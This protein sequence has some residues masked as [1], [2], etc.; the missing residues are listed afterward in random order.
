MESDFN[1]WKIK[2]LGIILIIYLCI[3]IL[4]VSSLILYG[5]LSNNSTASSSNTLSDSSKVY[6]HTTINNILEVQNDIQ[7]YFNQNQ[8]LPLTLNELYPTGIPSYAEDSYTGYPYNYVVN[9]SNTYELCANFEA[10][11]STNTQLDY[12][13]IYHNYGSYCLDFTA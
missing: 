10:S 7:T 13:N 1:L 3:L 8:Q 5:A 6:D 2:F 4:G 9:S 12:K 11:N